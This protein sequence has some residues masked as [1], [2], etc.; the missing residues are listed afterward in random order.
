MMMS[1]LTLRQEMTTERMDGVV[2][3]ECSS[4]RP[5]NVSSLCGNVGAAILIGL[6]TQTELD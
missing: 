4:P 3:V 1:K 6:R 5:P 2:G